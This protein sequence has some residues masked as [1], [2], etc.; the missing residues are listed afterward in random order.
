MPLRSCREKEP[1]TGSPLQMTFE[2]Y[3][4]EKIALYREFCETVR[5]ILEQA[6]FA[7]D[8]PRPQSLQC[9]PKD[10]K[11]LKKRLEELGSAGA[12]NIE[13]LR[14]DL[15]G[16]RIIFYTN[17]DVERFHSSQLIRDNF[18]I[19]KGGIK[20]HHPAQEN[21]ENQ[22][23][24]DHYTLRL[25]EDRTKLPE[26]AK[27][28]GLRC[29]LQV[30]TVLNHAWS[31]TSHDIIYKN[32]PREGFGT[33]AMELIEQRFNR[34]MK[35]YLLQAGYEFQRVQHD[36][37]RLQQGKALFDRDLLARLEAAADNN[38]R[39]DI[40]SSLKQ[41]VLPHYDD[42][43]AIYRDVVAALVDA[44]KNARSSPAV[45]IK[46]PF[47]ELPGK[48]ADE[49]VSVVVETISDFKYADVILSF[50][51]LRELYRDE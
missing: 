20:L 2:E 50:N 32:E 31:E 7:A 48:T 49:L 26:Y 35:N 4:T 11:R 14:R 17:T 21:D 13:E 25:K 1:F 10:P 37:E 38:E 6:I 5:R 30:Q 24:G 27:F 23:R 15:A 16:A 29:E 40:I 41:D 18:E 34:I 8:L 33:R 47:G 42:V 51:A 46:T 44:A 22:Y 19:E 3:E 12:D 45:P 9:R 36:Y 28:E 43:G 39:H